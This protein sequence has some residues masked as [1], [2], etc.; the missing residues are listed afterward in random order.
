M[1]QK[2]SVKGASLHPRKN[3]EF[4]ASSCCHHKW[5]GW[6][7]RGTLHFLSGKIFCSFWISFLVNFLFSCFFLL[8]KSVSGEFLG[9]VVIDLVKSYVQAVEF[10]TMQHDDELWEELIKQCL[11]KPEMVK[12]IIQKIC[13]Q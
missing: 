6:Y 5:T 13:S 8:S 9:L 11:D 2:K 1:H 3:G 4:Q 10:V 12:A 7:R